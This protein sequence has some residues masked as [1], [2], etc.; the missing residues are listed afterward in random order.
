MLP[1]DPSSAARAEAIARDAFLDF[2]EAA[3]PEDAAALRIRSGRIGRVGLIALPGVGWT[4]FNRGMGFGEP[5]GKA[6]FGRI[7]RWLRTH[8]APGWALQMPLTALSNPIRGWLVEAGLAPAGSGWAKHVRDA[9]PPVRPQR[10]DIEVRRLGTG[11]AEDFG[12]VAI[13][14]FGL[15][16]VL[17]RW[18]AALAGRSR[19]SVYAAYDGG[20]PAGVGAMFIADGL[21]WLGFDTTLPS[22][23]GRGSQGALI[24][25]RVADGIG[26]GLRGFVAETARSAAGRGPAPPSFRNYGRSGFSVAYVVVNYGPP[27]A[28]G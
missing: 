26:V 14:G 22:H 24:A 27:P 5:L 1:P 11:A 9:A 12:R 25:A 19:W 21:G 2:Y 20:A 17:R 23:R 6:E 4:E 28:G 7:V 3:S 15:P 8:G 10:T 13:E 18:F 16:P